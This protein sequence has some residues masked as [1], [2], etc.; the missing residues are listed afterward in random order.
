[1]DM[2]FLLSCGTLYLMTEY[3][4][5]KLIRYLSWAFDIQ[6]ISRDSISVHTHVIFSTFYNTEYTPGRGGPTAADKSENKKPRRRT[7]SSVCISTFSMKN[8][9]N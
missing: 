5:S 2:E 6:S 4:C 8:Q 1:M 9:C 7:A 3:T